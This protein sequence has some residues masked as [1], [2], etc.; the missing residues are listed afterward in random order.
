MIRKLI[1]PFIFV[2]GSF[3]L[4]A[5]TIRTD[6]TVIGGTAAGIS[7]AIQAARS[8]VKSMLIEP[9]PSL[10]PRF[11]KDDLVVL[12]RIRDHYIYKR[13]AEGGKVD[14]L[15]R[16]AITSENAVLILKSI[17]DTVKNMT[18]ML[19][20][21]LRDIKKDG[22]GWEIKLQNGRSVKTDVVID[23]STVSVISSMLKIDPVKTIIQTAI[24]LKSPILAP[25]LFRS[26]VGWGISQ[27]EKT[28][29]T[30]LIPVATLMPAGTENIFVI[31]PVSD[32]LQPQ[33]MLAG[34]AAG[35]SAAFCA[36]FK[37]TSRNL[38]I[39]LTQGEMLAYDAR[40]IPYTDIAFND[41]HALALQH[42]GLSGILKWKTAL[43]DSNEV[44]VFDTLGTITSEELR[45]PMKEYYSRSQIWFADH[46]TDSL[47][48]E[49][50]IN[51]LMFTATRGEE[52]RREIEEGWKKSFRFSSK[53]EPKRAINRR[54]FA[55]LTNRYLQ[56]FNIR[57]DFNG[58]LLN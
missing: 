20:T 18:V 38:N 21:G 47:S 53:Y 52:L 55:V 27:A 3:S 58:R 25:K 34:Q 10:N 46:K 8:G 44:F 1:L 39:R 30:Y 26:S 22:K 42:T 54:E 40:I 33:P 31:S 35:A 17:T 7:A 51:L 28:K 15:A 37:T 4:S 57:I 16:Q 43:K 14:S 56:P 50:A 45:L 49:D 9:G 5:Q 13:E 36:F 12:E 6:V 41:R 24:W 19:N 11:G 23:A 32:D 2:L 29:A 48:I